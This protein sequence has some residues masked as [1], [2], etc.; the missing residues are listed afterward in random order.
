[1]K[2]FRLKEYRFRINDFERM[3]IIYA[4]KTLLNSF[5]RRK[6]FCQDKPLEFLKKFYNI[7]SNEITKEHILAGHDLGIQLISDL[8]NK[9]EYPKRGRRKNIGMA[10]SGPS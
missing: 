9:F 8:I 7:N 5:K 4:L 2:Q 6:E 10:V 1:M 3:I